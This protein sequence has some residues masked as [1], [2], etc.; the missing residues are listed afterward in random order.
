M[1]LEER[2]NG[3]LPWTDIARI[4]DMDVKE[5]RR[6]YDSGILKMRKEMLDA[7]ISEQEFAAYIRHRYEDQ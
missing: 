6:L 3:L 4:L 1:H 5:V 7:G 2:N